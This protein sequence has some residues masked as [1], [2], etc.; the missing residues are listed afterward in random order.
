MNFG[1]RSESNPSVGIGLNFVNAFRNHSYF[2]SGKC[3]HEVHGLSSH[4]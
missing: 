3:I 1:E 2:G 4:M